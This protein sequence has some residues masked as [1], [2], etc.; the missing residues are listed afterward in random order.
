MSL[1][2]PVR[3]PVKY[4]SHLDAGAPQLANADGVIKTIL[5]AC[6]VTGYGTGA[7]EKAG[8]GWTAL[9]EDDFRIVLRRP[10][11]TGNPPDIK[12]EN[13]VINGA[14]SHRIISQDNPTGLDDTVELAA[15]NLLARSSATGVEWHLIASDFGFILCYKMAENGHV[16]QGLSLLYVGN[17]VGLFDDSA[18]M[19]AS[20]HTTTARD[21]KSGPWADG[22]MGNNAPLRN[23]SA[24]N[25]LTSKCIS[26]PLFS[27][28]ASGVYVAQ[29]IFVSTSD[30]MPFF[31]TLGRNFAGRATSIIAVDDRPMLRIYNALAL[32]QRPSAFYIPTD[33][34]EL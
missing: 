30:S 29:R 27:E 25:N 4:Y 13:G 34:W 6:L 28:S 17:L 21:G 32:N 19:Y 33:F 26:E 15:V 10:L 12:I 31:T 18:S 3:Y 22:F 11:R 8:A 20:Y 23:L 5:K 9:F 14:A 16:G 24:N 1:K 2:Q 7:D